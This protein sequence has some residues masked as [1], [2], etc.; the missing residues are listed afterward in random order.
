MPTTVELDDDDRRHLHSVFRIIDINND[1]LID[2]H[3]AKTCF[4]N[5][6]GGVS[7]TDEELEELFTEAGISINHGMSPEDFVH[8]MASAGANAAVSSAAGYGKQTSETIRK[9]SEILHTNLDKVQSLEFHDLR[10]QEM[11]ERNHITHKKP[12]LDDDAL[13]R[14]LDDKADAKCARCHAAYATADNNDE[15]CCYH[16]GKR[17]QVAHVGAN[18]DKIHFTCCEGE[19][20]G[21]APAIYKSPGCCRGRHLTHEEYEEWQ[22]GRKPS[23]CN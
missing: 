19:E 12:D 21:L 8:I 4:A 2:R 6:L 16:P 7:P 17:V 10:A 9:L 20:V 23:D 3:E 22:K 5:L 14:F 13:S 15:A 1:G 11:W 18:L